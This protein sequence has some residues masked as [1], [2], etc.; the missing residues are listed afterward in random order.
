MKLFISSLVFGLSLTLAACNSSSSGGGSKRNVSPEL[1]AFEKETTGEWLSECTVA[2]QGSYVEKLL[3]K[4]GGTGSSTTSY[5]NSQDCSGQVQ[6]TEGPIEFTYELS[7]SSTGEFKEVTVTPKGQKAIKSKFQIQGE[8]MTITNSD[9]TTRYKRIS[10][11]EGA[12]PIDG[13]NTGGSDFAR[14][15]LGTWITKD[16]Y[17]FEGETGSYKGVLTFSTESNGAYVYE[18]YQSANCSGQMTLS[19]KAEFKF[20]V[21]RFANGGG[22]ITIDQD[23]ADLYIQSNEM[24][25]VSAE[26]TAVYIRKN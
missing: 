14:M 5:F 16:C 25:I 23:I 26:S 17:Q 24:T 1:V 8:E 15:A 11:P 13:G 2:E 3:I 19:E 18:L 6:Q 12:K 4:S 10:R 7:A 22:Q 21:D 20:K 9:S